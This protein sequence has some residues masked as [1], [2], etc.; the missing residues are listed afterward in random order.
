MDLK[1]FTRSLEGWTLLSRIRV[2]KRIAGSWKDTLILA[3]YS[4]TQKIGD[5][6][7]NKQCMMLLSVLAITSLSSP[8]G[9]KRIQDSLADTLVTRSAV[10]NT[11]SISK[12][13]NQKFCNQRAGVDRSSLCRFDRFNRILAVGFNRWNISGQMA[14]SSSRKG[15]FLSGKACS[16]GQIRFETNLCPSECAGRRYVRSAESHR[17]YL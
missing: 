16:T 10:I 2:K 1:R 6:Y 5:P 14:V 12:L 4:R 7:W 3:K 11:F 17:F 15:Y 8:K 9:Y 13:D